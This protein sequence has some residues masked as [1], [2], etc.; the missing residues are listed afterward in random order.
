M[1]A[2]LHSRVLSNGLTLVAERI[3]S[4]RSAAFQFVVPAGATT[5]PEAHCGVC[6]V[7]EGM[8]YRG[9]GARSARELS[10]ALDGLGIQRS[11]GAELEC[12]TY[13][14]SL[15]A[16]DLNAALEL[17]SDIL[18]RPTFPDSQL[19]PEVDLALQK[20]DRLE[21]NPAE[22]L[23]LA[24]RKQYYPGAYGRTALGTREGLRSLTIECV[25]TEHARRYRPD[26]SILAL[27]GRFDFES[28]VAHLER[29]LSNWT[30]KA[31]EVESA[32]AVETSQYLHIE[33]PANQQQIGVMYP[34]V[35]V[36]HPDCYVLRMA[37]AALSGGMSARLFTELREKRGLCYAV[38]ASLITVKGDGAVLSYVGT[39]PEQCQ[40][41]LDVLMAEHR[42]L[43]DG[44]S[45]D[46]L[47]RA[48]TGV[49]S[50]LV[51]QGEATRARALHLARDQMLLG[52]VRPLDE[53]RARL[54]EVTPERIHEYLQA[55][56]L[57]RCTIVSLGPTRLE[58]SL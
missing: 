48:R 21:D 27:A 43:A 6:G 8:S 32:R 16:D 41:S 12:V 11:G 33:Q 35:S 40:T 34:G 31:P 29:L 15:L 52:R 3:P 24:M 44:V 23:F 1:A 10:Q 5:D 9:A 39:T 38:R 2:S 19:Q 57:E 51:M 7:L 37:I 30:G 45:Q 50:S 55:H 22:K 18:L 47:E 42:R 26:G 14:A 28:V 58:V 20:L 36:E 46:E 56:P 25:R 53:I 4:V 17:Y 13:G 54:M 49:L